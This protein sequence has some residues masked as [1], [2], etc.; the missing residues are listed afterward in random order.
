[1]ESH[2]V[3][4]GGQSPS[5]S[6]GRVRRTRSGVFGATNRG[7]SQLGVRETGSERRIVRRPPLGTKMEWRTTGKS[8]DC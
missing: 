4:D 6:A 2:A 3:R 8:V 1:M 5:R 7:T